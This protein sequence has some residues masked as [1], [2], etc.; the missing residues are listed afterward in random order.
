MTKP[1][2]RVPQWLTIDLTVIAISAIIIGVGL[3][4]GLL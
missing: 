4:I 2:T 1:T 3:W